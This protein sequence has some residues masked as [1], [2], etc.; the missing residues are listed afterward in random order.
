MPCAVWFLQRFSDA[1]DLL[2]GVVILRLQDGL[3]ISHIQGQ[4]IYINVT[5]FYLLLGVSDN[6]EAKMLFVPID[7]LLSSN[8]KPPAGNK[9]VMISVSV[10]T[11]SD[12]CPSKT[13]SGQNSPI[14]I[15][16]E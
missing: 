7:D 12:S 14:I 5:P 4:G 16:G 11:D 10:Q 6:K 1:F 3:D 15:R 8:E 2:F 9:E 13:T